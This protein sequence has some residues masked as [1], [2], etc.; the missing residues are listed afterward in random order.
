MNKHTIND[1]MFRALGVFIESLRPYVVDS[2]KKQEEESWEKAYYATL[3]PGQR[4]DWDK[5]RTSG[6]APESLIDFGNLKGFSLAYKSLLAKDFGKKA[7][8]LPTWFDDIAAVR[9]KCQHYTPLGTEEATHAYTTMLM[10]LD[11]LDMKDAASEIRQIKDGKTTP[12]IKKAVGVK[13]TAPGGVLPWFKNVQPHLDIRQGHLDESLFAANLAEVALDN[14]REIYKNPLMFFS[15]TYPTEGLK[16]VLKRV[17][18]GLNGKA[19]AENRVISLQTGFGG[20]KTHVLIALLHYVT[21]G[22]KV[23]DS[24]YTRD[25]AEAVGVPDFDRANVAVFTNTTNDPVQGRTEDGATLRTLWGELAWQ[26]AGASGKPELYEAVRPNDESR[27]SPKGLF[28]KVLKEAG[29]CLILIDELADYCVAASGVQVG[30]STLSDQT[31]SF[32][33]E[34]SEAVSRVDR[35]VL[36]ATLP[37]SAVEVANSPGASA[38]LASLEGRLARVGADTKP[39]AEEEIFEVIRRRLFEDIPDAGAVSAA[40]TPYMSLYGEL[41]SELPAGAVKTAYRQ[42]LMRSYPFHPELIDMFRLR[43]AGNSDFQ[44]TRGVL[45]ILAS[46]VSDLWKRQDSLTGSNNFIHTSDVNFQTLDALVGQLKKLYGNGYEAVISADVSGQSSNAFRIDVQQPDFQKYGI[47]RGV[48]ATILL[49]SFGGSGVNKGVGIDEIKLAVIRPGTFNHNSVNGALDALEGSAHYLYYSSSG[50]PVK[51]YWFHTK[52]NMNIL[53][54]GARRDVETESVHGEI[55]TRLKVKVGNVSPFN[56]LVDPSGDIPEQTKP[57]I[58]ILGPRYRANP[59]TINSNTRPVIEKIAGKR[60]NIERIYRNTIIFLI[61]SEPGYAKLK[62]DLT[63]FL[64]CKKIRDEYM[65]QFEVDQKDD[66]RQRINEASREADR[67]LVAAYSIVA[68]H[69][70]KEGIKSITLKHFSDE[71][72][73]QIN[74]YLLQALKDEEWYLESIG[75]NTL[76]K[77]QLLPGPEGAIKTKDIHEAFIRFDDKPIISGERA[78]RESLLRYCLNGELVIASGDGSE[79]NAMY[80]KETVPYFEVSDTSYWVLD[81]SRYQSAKQEPTAGKTF[82]PVGVEAGSEETAEPTEE[83]IA[84]AENIYKKLTISGK[85]DIANYHQVFTSFVH[86]LA[87]N[88]VEIEIRIHGRSTEDFPITETSDQYRITKESAKQLGLEFEAE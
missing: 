47:A 57:T 53:I 36:V 56:V 74:N 8:N 45:R 48:A 84:P 43:W 12:A 9:N 28:M 51:R 54:N 23:R 6:S 81:K 24:G 75:L 40:V 10:I 59:Q 76:K 17:V 25:L 83:S 44:R 68:K 31:I 37:A 50:A 3:Y 27:T 30:G 70:A 79:F 61:C 67:S 62:D 58:V 88:G 13:T 2:L 73:V 32:I 64:A 82:A 66:L 11:I 60:G 52:P 20:G 14:G 49:G 18:A 1:D 26:L 69:S 42:R 4:T 41:A 35:C 71:I 33:Q 38:I 29:P 63:E 39:V 16:A 15:K 72:D 22:K 34:L 55:V 5:G 86:P 7:M 19:E 85:I 77:Y 87:K 78:V 21:M 65:G 46:I 80:Y